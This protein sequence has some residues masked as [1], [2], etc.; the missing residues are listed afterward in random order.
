MNGETLALPDIAL[1]LA[2]HHLDID[3]PHVGGHE[4]RA[5]STN[6]LH[7]LHLRSGL[8]LHCCIRF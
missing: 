5:I 7:C 2:L 4:G 3:L 8:G 6:H 1:D